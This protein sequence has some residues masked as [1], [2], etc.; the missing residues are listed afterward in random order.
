M[1]LFIE[2]YNSDIKKIYLCKMLSVNVIELWWFF[3]NKYK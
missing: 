1:I 2:I 3:F